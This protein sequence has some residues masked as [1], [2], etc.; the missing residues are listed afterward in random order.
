MCIRKL[1]PGTL[2]D[3]WDKSES[4]QYRKIIPGLLLVVVVGMGLSACAASNGSDQMPGVGHAL[5]T[6]LDRQVIHADAPLDRSA[7][8]D[9]PGDIADR[10]Y[11][12]RY[13]KTMTEDEDED[14]KKATQAFQ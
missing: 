13:I 4:R 10:I 14:E 11:T 12:Q 8:G 2:I 3:R 1:T 7:V 9:L 6:G 5:I